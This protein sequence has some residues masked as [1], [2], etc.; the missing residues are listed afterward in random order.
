VSGLGYRWRHKAD[1][2]D[3]RDAVDLVD[4]VAAQAID[5]WCVRTCRRVPAVAAACLS[6][7]TK[8]QTAN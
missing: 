7:S 4:A 2:D 3:E 6:T 1:D 5:G 8:E